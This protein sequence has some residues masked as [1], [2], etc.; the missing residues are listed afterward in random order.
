MGAEKCPQGP[1]LISL[2]DR[3]PLTSRS[4]SLWYK[5][6]QVHAV[7]ETCAHGQRGSWINSAGAF[8]AREITEKTRKTGTK[9][10]GKA[11]AKIRRNSGS[12]RRMCGQE[13]VERG[14][15]RREVE[16]EVEH[17]NTELQCAFF[18]PIMSFCLHPSEGSSVP[19]CPGPDG[20][21]GSSLCSPYL[22]RGQSPCRHAFTVCFWG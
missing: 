17:R 5:A 16:E 14:L 10:G 4:F 11:R 21:Q 9:A 2:K 7:S 3:L 15:C 22:A 18:P 12:Q 8:W 19:P 20:E 13:G 1:L 6:L